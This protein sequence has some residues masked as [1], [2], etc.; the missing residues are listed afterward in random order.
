MVSLLVGCA[1]GG[2]RL[3]RALLSADALQFRQRVGCETSGEV[4]GA[5][6]AAKAT[7]YVGAPAPPA[8]PNAGAC[9]RSPKLCQ[10]LHELGVDLL[11]MSPQHAM[12]A[13]FQL[14]EPD[15]LDHLRL[16]SG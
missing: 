7:R 6:R 16:S 2:F 12:G 8:S 4:T 3:S 9:R 5:L 11:R 15:I 10:K 1:S 13:T 14:H